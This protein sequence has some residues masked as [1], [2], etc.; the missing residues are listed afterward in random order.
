[1]RS[2]PQKLGR[3]EDVPKLSANTT[4]LMILRTMPSVKA[5]VKEALRVGGESV[6]GREEEG[7]LGVN[8]PR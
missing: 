2:T 4:T 5:M 1:M 6:K 8:R 3:D 7:E